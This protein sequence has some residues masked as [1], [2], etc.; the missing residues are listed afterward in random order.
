MVNALNFEGVKLSPFQ[1]EKV[2]RLKVEP[3][4]FFQTTKN[5]LSHVGEKVSGVFNFYPIWER[6]KFVKQW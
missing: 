6:N 1:T 2:G 3:T 4:K 5:F